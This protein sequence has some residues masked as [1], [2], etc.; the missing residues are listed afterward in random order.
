[1]K[2]SKE[3]ACKMIDQMDQH[4]RTELLKKDGKIQEEK[5]WENIY[6][7]RQIDKRNSGGSFSLEDHIRA[8]VYSMLS[9]SISWDRIVKDIEPET[10]CLASIDDIFCNYDV[11]K[12]IKCTPEQLRD[13]LKKLHCA[14]QSTLSQMKA[15]LSVNVSKLVA[16]EKEYGDIDTYYRRVIEIDGTLKS[17]IILL[18]T[19]GSI[20]KM[21]QM[22]IALVCEYLRNVG[23]DIPKPDRHICR[24]LG[25]DCLAILE[26]KNTKPFEAFDLVVELAEMTGKSVAETDYILWS[27]CATGYGEIC[28][29]ENP[30]CEICVANMICEGNLKSR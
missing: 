26:G 20:D 3:D 7:K 4:L 1:M 9:S 21:D 18:S 27:Y 15:L 11:E 19:E 16:R 6:I 10:G 12:L 5:L 29:K 22:N 8:M 23:H 14:S 2:I 30:K 25:K 24:I 17:L 28:T 13:G